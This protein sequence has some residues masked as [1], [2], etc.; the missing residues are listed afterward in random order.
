MYLRFERD[1]NTPDALFIEVLVEHLDLFLIQ[2]AFVSADGNGCDLR[3]Y[4]P[5]A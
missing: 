3:I 2:S 4:T 5:N 1:A